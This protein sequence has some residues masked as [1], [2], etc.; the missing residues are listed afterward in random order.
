MLP[1]CHSCH[2]DLQPT[3]ILLIAGMLILFLV[4]DFFQVLVLVLFLGGQVLV[5]ILVL[6]GQVQE[7]LVLVLGGQVLVL[8]LVLGGQV[9]VNIPGFN[10]NKSCT[11]ARLLAP[12][13]G[14]KV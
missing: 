9:L 4:L 13:D 2:A 6:G 12:A 3:A 5:L 14:V 11:R 8:V 10:K 7:V 1:L